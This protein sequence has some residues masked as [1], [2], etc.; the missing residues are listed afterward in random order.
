MNPVAEPPKAKHVRRH[1]PDF[2]APA[3]DR[4]LHA[5]DFSAGSRTAFYHA[6]KAALTARAHFTIVFI[7]GKDASTWTEFPGVREVL[8]R[9]GLFKLDRPKSP[10]VPLGIHVRK[11]VTQ[12]NP[13][14]SVLDVLD[15]HPADLIVLSTHTHKRRVKWLKKSI[16]KPIGPSSARMTL[17]IPDHVSGFVSAVDGSVALDRILI[18]VAARPDPQPALYAAARVAVRLK[19][20]RGKFTLLHVGDDAIPPV[21]FPAVPGW[22]WNIKRQ[23]G[24]ITRGILDTARKESTDLIVM[25]TDG[26]NGFL[27]ALRGSHSERVLRNAPCP[28]LTVPDESLAGGTSRN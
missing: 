14:K 26:R 6:L 2:R 9:W 27:D 17:F 11:V 16:A 18:P 1:A 8:T 5:S 21:Q 12:G 15:K 22:Q 24:D 3:I 4:V 7:A 10:L 20:P 28:L 13:V 25:S 23:T 19:C